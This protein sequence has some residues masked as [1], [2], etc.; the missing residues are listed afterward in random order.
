MATQTVRTIY[1]AVVSGAQRN[2][3]NLGKTLDRS[4][5]S[6]DK[7]DSAL[8]KAGKRTVRPNIDLD[9]AT[10]EKEVRRLT[11]DLDKL[12]KST[13][14]VQ[15]DAEVAQAQRAVDILTSELSVLENAPTVAAIDA[16]IQK[17]QAKSDTLRRELDVLSRMEPSLQVQ[18]DTAKAESALEDIENRLKALDGARADA[19]ATVDADTRAATSA[20][21]DAQQRLDDING[22]RAEATVT[23]DIDAARS[24]LEQASSRLKALNGEKAELQVLVDSESAQS[25]LDEMGDAAESAGSDA[26]ARAGGALLEGLNSTP[27]VG[28]IGGLVAAVGG[29]I[30]YGIIDSL[31]ETMRAEDVFGARTGLDE[32]TSRKFGAAAGAAYANAWGESIDDNL[33]T[34]QSALENALIGDGSTG[35]EVEAVIAQLSAVS[36][37]LDADVSEAAEAAGNMIKNGLAANAEEA[38]DI[39]VNGSQEGLNRSDDLLDTLRE[40]S[41]MFEAL[42]L[43]GS[44]ALGLIDQAMDAGARNSDVAADALKEFSIRAQDDS[45]ATNK[46]YEEIGLNAEEMG[47][48][49]AAGGEEAQEGLT[50]VLDA[51]RG[52]EDPMA[53]NAAGVALFGTMWED[54]G[55]GAGILAMDLD[56]L[57]GSW[58]NV[59]DTASD[60]MD[61]MSDNAATDLEEMKRTLSNAGT[62]LLGGIASALEEPIN[63][64]ADYVGEN[65]AEIIGFLIDVG[66]EFFDVARA[67]T[68]FAATTVEVLGDVA[69]SLDGIV[70]G[71]GKAIEAIGVMTDDE[72]MMRLGQG[73][74]DASKD[75]TQFS[76]DADGM[77]DTLRTTVGGALD[78]AEAKFDDWSGPALMQ[79]QIDDAITGMV[80]GL[81]GFVAHVDSL[82]G[83]TVTINGDILPGEEAMNALITEVDESNG[84][85]TIN[86]KTVPA[87]EA[88][89]TFIAETEANPGAEVTVTANTGPAEEAWAGF[90]GTVMSGEPPEIPVGADTSPAQEQVTI[91]GSQVGDVPAHVYVEADLF[92]AEESLQSFYAT[93]NEQGGTVT[94]NG[95]TA[96]ARE[97][98][99]VLIEEVN[100]GE[101]TV[102]INGTPVNAETSLLQLVDIIN[103]SGGVVEIDGDNVP[104]NLKTDAAKRKIDGTE[105]TVDIDGDASGANSATDGAKRKADGTKGTIKVDAATAAA[106]AAIDAAAW[107][108]T[109]TIQVRAVQ[110]GRTA[111]SIARSV[112]GMFGRANGGRIATGLAYGGTVGAGYGVVPAPYPGPGIDNVLWPL[113]GAATGRVLG[114]PLAGGEWVVNPISSAQHDSTLRAINDGAT[115][116]ELASMLGAGST[117]PDYAAIAAASRAGV[118]EGMAGAQVLIRVGH[119]TVIGAIV[120]AERATGRK[121]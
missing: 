116:A 87:D 84:Y 11:G 120:D 86:G 105:G 83:G 61:R 27:V 110:V 30:T 9:I 1:E 97:T 3:S 57:G 119:Q 46:A 12:E 72:D 71:I 17:A 41:S 55:N 115:R 94:I 23:A 13:P 112:A 107:T 34:A 64:A 21:E 106:S 24:D 66:H 98:L 74:Q 102:M 38:F 35:R 96:D 40:Y 48:K 113:K 7:L 50:I 77:A 2:V 43:D 45:K 100:N 20:L 53:R 67:A 121:I 19:V 44:E 78:D 68:E 65:T 31:L 81:D 76:E 8:D 62:N 4:A 5:D 92:T 91:W 33:N 117:A 28:A 82:P 52:I 14:N 22:I 29:Y 69:G 60:A 70:D 118:A 63:A 79:A 10:A 108:R 16:D 56:N 58:V 15:I 101:G 6:A 26:G 49:V 73:I 75:M 47:K 90:T 89:A 93:M 36:E 103:S 88:V 95:E 32:V 111:A 39:I 18:A 51:L 85:V 42:G 59:G 54:M 109:A 104:A 25:S 37:I 114:Q 80:A 99:D